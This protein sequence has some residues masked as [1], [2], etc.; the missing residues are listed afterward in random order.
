MIEK[1]ANLPA[2]E[3]VGLA[4]ALILLL[5]MIVDAVIAKPLLRYLGA[6]EARI[7]S[8]SAELEHSRDVIRYSDSVELQYEAVKDL[9]GVTGPESETVEAFKNELDEMSIKQGV[10]L[11]SM[12]HLPPESTDYLV[13]YV[14]EVG[15]FETEAPALIRFLDTISSAP[16]LMRVREI[17]VSSQQTNRVVNGSMVITKVMTLPNENESSPE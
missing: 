8:T 15:D 4:V 14:V 11:R 9:L 3:R 6:Q 1:L 2:R 13:T 17:S 5:M 10:T 16:G 7:T 12:R